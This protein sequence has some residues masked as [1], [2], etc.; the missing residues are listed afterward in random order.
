MTDLDTIA[1]EIVAHYFLTCTARGGVF[2]RMTSEGWRH[3]PIERIRYFVSKVDPLAAA[4]SNRRLA[5]VSRLR[6]ICPRRAPSVPP[7]HDPVLC[8]G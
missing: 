6:E 3:V 7:Q 5:I 8:H 4:D 2:Y 1:R